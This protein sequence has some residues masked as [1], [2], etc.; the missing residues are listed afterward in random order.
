MK[1]GFFSKDTLSSFCF[2]T[3]FFLLILLSLGFHITSYA[4]H[5]KET[6]SIYSK[7]NL[8]AWCIVPYDSK[9]RTPEERAL[10]LKKLGITKLAYDWREKHIPT[11]DEEL[12]ALK[13]HGI[14]LQAFWFMSG[15]EPEKDKNLHL[16]L[17]M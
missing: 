8:V 15:L 14:K 7:N 11:F 4:Q 6:E 3:Y 17:D 10:M 12:V 2:K 9:N 1:S 13:K 5:Q 16:I